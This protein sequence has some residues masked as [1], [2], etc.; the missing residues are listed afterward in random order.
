MFLTVRVRIRVNLVQVIL[1]GRILIYVSLILD[2]AVESNMCTL[3]EKL[4][5]KCHHMILAKLQYDTSQA[6]LMI[7]WSIGYSRMR[8]AGR[9]IYD[10][11]QKE[12]K[13][14]FQL[15]KRLVLVSTAVEEL[16]EQ[17]DSSVLQL[18]NH[19]MLVSQCTTVATTS[20]CKA[21][22][23]LALEQGKA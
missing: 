23:P 8:G 11:S 18:K 19:V 9:V 16:V 15:F 1:G 4:K 20:R 21:L 5:R 22:Q 6:S 12:S 13:P 7:L 14:F 2:L 17:A 10:K 3:N